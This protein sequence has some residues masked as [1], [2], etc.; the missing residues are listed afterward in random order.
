MPLFTEEWSMSFMIHWFLCVGLSISGKQ[1]KFHAHFKVKEGLYYLIWILERMYANHLCYSPYSYFISVFDK[2][3]V[4]L[5]DS[6][7]QY[8]NLD[9]LYIF[10]TLQNHAVCFLAEQMSCACRIKQTRQICFVLFNLIILS[11]V[12]L[13]F[14][15]RT[16]P[17]VT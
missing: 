10:F 12:E 14:D 16:E 17:K 4:F 15:S 2:K 9:T 6:K 7:M 3:N 5:L 13:K 8:T 11:V 1:G